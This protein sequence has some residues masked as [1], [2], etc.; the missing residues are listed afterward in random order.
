MH[1]L[2]QDQ[3]VEA[4]A[5]AA[6]FAW[7]IDHRAGEGVSGLFTPDGMYGY[8]GFEMHGREAID[9]FYRERAVRGKRL[10]RHVFTPARLALE[11][12]NAIAA[13][14]TLTLYAADGEAPHPASPIALM[15]YA[16]RLVVDDGKL[17]FQQRWVTLLFGQMPRLV[18]GQDLGRQQS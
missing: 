11:D 15:D 2:T 1:A 3:I 4:A 9:L 16:D 13:W 8:T 12:H 6:E 18:T 5:L 10:S 17:R 14:S 7:L